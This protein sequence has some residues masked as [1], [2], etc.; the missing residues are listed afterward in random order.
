MK[1]VN[2]KLGLL[3][4]MAGA[5][6]TTGLISMIN[7]P[8]VQAAALS[9]SASQTEQLNLPI[10][11]QGGSGKLNMRLRNIELRDLLKMLSKR[12]GFNILLDESVEGLISVDLIDISVNQ[13]LETVKN[14]ANLVYM[15]DDKTLVISGKD[16]TL[17]TSISQQISQMIP[18]KYVNAKLIAQL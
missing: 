7:V 2:L 15:Q 4:I 11:V 17:A 5:V 10:T 8:S 9:A 18:V 13:A 3:S 1:V 16:S 6:I 14:Y 12:A